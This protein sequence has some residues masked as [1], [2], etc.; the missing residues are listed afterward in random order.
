MTHTWTHIWTLASPHL[1]FVAVVLFTANGRLTAFAAPIPDVAPDTQSQV[2]HEHVQQDP[3]QHKHGQKK[4]SQAKARTQHPDE[5]RP[6]QQTQIM[7][8][9]RPLTIGGSVSLTARYR[10]NFSLRD[11]AQEDVFRLD[12]KL[13][14][15]LF[16]PL[17]ERISFFVEGKARYQDEL[18]KEGGNRRVRYALERGE[19]WLSID[20]FLERFVGRHWSLQI[21]RQK[22]RESQEWWWDENLDAIRLH[23]DRRKFHA[24]I[25]LAQEVMQPSTEKDQVDSDE[26]DVLRF[27]GRTKWKW[28][29]WLNLEGFFL[30]LHDYSDL[31]TVGQ[32]VPRA[33]RDRFDAQLL[34]LG[35][36]ASGKHTLDR[37][38]SLSYQLGGA[39]GGGQEYAFRFRSIDGHTSQIRSRRDYR[40]SGWAFDSQL[41][42]R[43]RGPD[44]PSFTFGHAFG[45]GDQSPQHGTESAFRQ[46]GIHDNAGRFQGRERFRYYGELLRPELSNLHIWT[47]AIGF[48]FWR[49]S[50]VELIY[51]LYHQVYPTP[52]L[53]SSRIKAKPLGTNPWIGQ[54]WNLVLGLA[55][56]EHLEIKLIGSL[57]RAGTAYGPLAGKMAYGSVV[58]LE[59]NF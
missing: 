7:L 47:A 48:R 5:S 22:I 37:W 34:W 33:R 49:A 4:Q 53:R 41:S 9:G 24:E 51:H 56:W 23:Y 35:L 11:S 19:V 39:W 1:L 18:Y 50:S 3:I 57:F 46:T 2:R 20:R 12:H 15:E 6:A 13:E 31:P 25:A 42:W 43:T 59:Y 45:S 14:L 26:E 10:G 16:Y 54:E 40:V 44:R 27:L 58:Q 36:R 52:F 8:F 29:K 55:E 21:G 32:L 30:Y 38:G 28:K 17:T